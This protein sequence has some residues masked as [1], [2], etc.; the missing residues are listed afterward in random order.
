MKSLRLKMHHL[1]TKLPYQRPKLRQIEWWVQNGPISK[2]GVMLRTTLF[3]RKFCF[4]LRTSYKELIWCTNYPNAHIRTFCKH[5][6]FIW[7]CFF[8][9][10]TLNLM[11]LTKQSFQIWVTKLA[12]FWTKPMIHTFNWLPLLLPLCV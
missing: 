3:F 7:R 5:W 10:R 12:L 6:S 8:P 2:N 1:H 9:V 4:S 11:I